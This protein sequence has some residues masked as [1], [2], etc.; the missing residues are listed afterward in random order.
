[1]RVLPTCQRDDPDDEFGHPRARGTIL[2]R[3]LH[4]GSAQ[5]KALA[6]VDAAGC[7]SCR[8]RGLTRCRDT[9]FWQ[10]DD[11]CYTRRALADELA[12]ICG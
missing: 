10:N 11:A 8:P 1:M 2:G 9:Q 4:A 7:E 6:R 3:L 5:A 12:T